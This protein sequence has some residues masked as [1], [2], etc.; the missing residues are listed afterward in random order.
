MSE[1]LTK[2]G[3]QKAFRAFAFRLEAIAIKKE[4][5]KERKT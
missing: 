2:L 4:G 3:K 1:K 5:K